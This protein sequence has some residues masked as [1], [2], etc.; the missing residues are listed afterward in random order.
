LKSVFGGDQ[1]DHN[2]ISGNNIPD[3]FIQTACKFVQ[4]LR[5]ELDQNEVRALAANR[6]ASPVLQVR[7][8]VFLWFY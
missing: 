3:E 8:I 1:S 5:K 6:V 2:D 7:M 4:I